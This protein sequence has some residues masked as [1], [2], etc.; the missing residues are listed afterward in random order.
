M[1]W[2]A[3]GVAL[4]LW[5]LASFFLAMPSPAAESAHPPLSDLID[6][7]FANPLGR[8]GCAALWLLAGAALL[9]RGRGL[10]GGSEMRAARARQ[11][12]RNG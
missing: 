12:G 1:L 10:P 5:E 4:C 3:A 11:K 2:A 9:R 7:I 6:P 8:A